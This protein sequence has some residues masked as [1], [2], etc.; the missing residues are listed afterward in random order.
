M[1]SLLGIVAK[2]ECD[3]GSALLMLAE[4]PVDVLDATAVDDNDVVDIGVDVDELVADT[5]V[6]TRI[7]SVIWIVDI[8]V[9]LDVNT[10]RG[11]LPDEELVIVVWGFNWMLLLLA[12]TVVEVVV[13]D[14]FGPSSSLSRR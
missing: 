2:G 5:V 10:L 13:V 4:R 14:S 9:S 7:V 8:T 12:D 3:D 11:Y 1:R 6:G